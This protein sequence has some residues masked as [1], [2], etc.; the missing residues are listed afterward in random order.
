MSQPGVRGVYC[1]GY[2]WLLLLFE[3]A[4]KSPVSSLLAYAGQEIA[5][6]I[7]LS[8]DLEALS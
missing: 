3:I 4:L 2:S 1:S 5:F 7:V 8:G 6:Y